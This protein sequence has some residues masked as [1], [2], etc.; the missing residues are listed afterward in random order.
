[1]MRKLLRAAMIA[2]IN[3]I[4]HAFARAR[5]MK[6]NARITG[7]REGRGFCGFFSSQNS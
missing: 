3:L 7:C 6:P 1:M 2:E 4:N 5:E